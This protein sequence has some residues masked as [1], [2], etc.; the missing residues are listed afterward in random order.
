MD[1]FL[2]ALQQRRDDGF[3]LLEIVVAVSIM[4]ILG[5]A[6]YAGY[7]MIQENSRQ[8]ATQ[9]VADQFANEVWGRIVREGG[10][11]TSH[12]AQVREDFFEAYPDGES[13]FVLTRT[14]TVN[15]DQY[16]CIAVSYDPTASHVSGKIGEPLP[17]MENEHVISLSGNNC[18]SLDRTFNRN[19]DWYELKGL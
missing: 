6:G 8:A 2:A 15:V 5:V 12:I 17:I 10:T 13:N 11:P 3:S 9:Q 7:G 18:G 1:K 4:L 14:S 19:Y 16:F